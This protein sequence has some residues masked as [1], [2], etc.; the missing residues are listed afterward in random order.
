MWARRI[1]HSVNAQ[2]ICW[3]SRTLRRIL[4]AAQPY[5]HSLLRKSARN[6][7][8]LRVMSY[9][10]RAARRADNSALAF[11]WS[12]LLT[13]AV[14]QRTKTRNLQ[15]CSSLIRFLS[16]GSEGTC[17][18]EGSAIRLTR[19]ISAGVATLRRILRAAQPYTHFGTG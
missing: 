3:L 19:S 6:G 12:K 9:E 1:C 10:F 16:G 7:Y 13:H 2:P 17:G 4:R 18:N 8:E 5:T 15:L 14:T 11:A